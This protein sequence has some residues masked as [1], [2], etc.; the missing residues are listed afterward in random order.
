MIDK[1]LEK[2][3]LNSENTKISLTK[4][5]ADHDEDEKTWKVIAPTIV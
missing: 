1:G 2:N 4:D 3:H 5:Q